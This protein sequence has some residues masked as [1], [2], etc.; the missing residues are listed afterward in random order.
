MANPK[1]ELEAEFLAV[2]RLIGR[3]T[4]PEKLRMHFVTANGLLARIERL[5]I[6]P[7]QCA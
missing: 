6:D 7:P 1:T 2:C 5:T 3:T 4:D